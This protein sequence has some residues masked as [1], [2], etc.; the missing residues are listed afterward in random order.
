V[1]QCTSDCPAGSCRNPATS[2]CEK[3]LPGFANCTICAAG[4]YSNSYYGASNC[5]T[6][7]DGAITSQA[8]QSTCSKCAAGKYSLNR[9]LCIDCPSGRWSREASSTCPICAAWYY[10]AANG[11]CLACPAGYVSTAGDTSCA[12]CVPGRFL[13]GNRNCSV[14]S[15]GRFTS[16]QNQTSCSDCGYGMYNPVGITASTNDCVECSPGT[17]SEITYSSICKQCAQGYWTNRSRSAICSVCPLRDGVSCPQGSSVPYVGSG[18]YRE[19]ATPD[20]ISIC[21]PPNACP[22]AENGSTI[23]SVEYAGSSCSQCSTNYFRSGTRCVKCLSKGGRWAIIV[24]VAICLVFVVSKLVQKQTLIPNSLKVMLYWVQFLSLL[25]VISNSWPPTLENLLR[26]TSVVNF[27][28]GYFGVGCDLPADSYFSVL[29]VKLLLPII[30]T[31][32]LSISRMISLL[33]KVRQT[34]GLKELVSQSIFVANFFAVQLLS[35]MFQVF[36]CRE[37]SPG[38]FV[39]F[40]EPSVRCYDK[41]W[42]SFVAADITFMFLYAV[43]GPFFFWYHFKKHKF[44][45]SDDEG[46]RK[47]LI[48]PLIKQYRKGAAWFE[49]VRLLLR[50]CFIL[51]RDTIQMTSSGKIIFMVLMLLLVNWIESMVRPYG[52]SIQQNFSFL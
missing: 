42:W 50:L 38:L 51:L 39:I 18:L 46:L 3:S 49:F 36:N 23:C 40:Q 20:L 7:P 8:G 4:F 44:D 29:L 10:P 34:F 1:S 30:F 22:A 35:A 12:V 45:T 37:L 41:S 19:L 15:L 6:C 5:S 17:Y 31:V 32:V 27:D 25:P 21:L 47:S 13:D 33:L 48:E 9:S 26:F 2:L 14:C 43:L 11:T 52:D 24:L 28:I 16:V